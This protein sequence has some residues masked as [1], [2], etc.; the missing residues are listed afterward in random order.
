MKKTINKSGPVSGVVAPPPRPTPLGAAVV[1][2]I[3]TFP[4]GVTLLV[5]DLLLL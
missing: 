2:A 3:I 1:A 5:V 4:I